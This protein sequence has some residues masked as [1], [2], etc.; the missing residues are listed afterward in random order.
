[1]KPSAQLDYRDLQA[2][3]AYK[4]KKLKIIAFILTIIS[5]FVTGYMVGAG[6]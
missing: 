2:I 6:I 4:I 5:L 3:A 1:M